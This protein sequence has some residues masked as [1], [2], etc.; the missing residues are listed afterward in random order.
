M[1]EIFRARVESIDV[2]RGLVMILMALDHT[3]DFFGLPG[4]NPTEM[5]STTVPL[6]FT[7][8]ITHL[9]APTFFLLTGTG[10]YLARGRRTTARV[11]WLLLTRGLWLIVL[12]L[13][14][15]RF[16]LQFNIDYRVT[17]LL[18]IWALGW[19]MITLSGLAFLPTW[20][21]AVFGAVMICGH[22]LLD[23]IRAASFGSVAP[24]WAILHGPG[25]ALATPAH[26]VFAGYP[27]IP[28]IGVTA[29]GYSLG[30]L[31]RT[32]R[33]RR[34]FLLPAGVA[35]TLVFIVLRL[36]NIYG[37]P[38]LRGPQR[39]WALTAV[40]FLNVTKYPPSLSFLL[41]T[42]GP[43]AMLLWLLE[44]KPARLLRPALTLGRVPLFYF[45]FHFMLIHLLAVVTCYW[46]Y[47]EAHWMFE[48]P[49]LAAYPFTPPP[50][51]GFNLPVVYAIWISVVLLMYPLCR[52]YASVK[53]RRT[54]WWL[55]YL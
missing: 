18:V 42:L 38:A 36:L 3:R 54:D 49:S 40:S 52:W 29:V 23:P 43:A 19:S 32:D 28:W 50:D 51:W 13:T 37:D 22:N 26:V 27:L 46:R 31:Y 45:L 15:M 24:I 25:M 20:A 55:S 17:M 2:L 33:N 47:G 9:C 16:A 14:V 34:R 30:A 10:A 44:A 1:K 53:A 12:E 11:S 6:F 5:A 4:A 41:M 21:V 48:S 39:S 7:R 35:L 8:W